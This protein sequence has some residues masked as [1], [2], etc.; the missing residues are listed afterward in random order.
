MEDRQRQA[1][2]TKEGLGGNGGTYLSPRGV[3]NLNK[4]LAQACQN[5]SGGETTTE[6]WETQAHRRRWTG[7]TRLMETEEMDL[8]RWYYVL[9]RYHILIEVGGKGARWLSTVKPDIW[10]RIMLNTQPWG[11]KKEKQA[12]GKT[13]ARSELCSCLFVFVRTHQSPSVQTHYII[14]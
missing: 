13:T 7:R 11:K 1:V 4:Y 10:K 5:K 9:A 6:A 3:R 14:V 2:K 12:G 8:M